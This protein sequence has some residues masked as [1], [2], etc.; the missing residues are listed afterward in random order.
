[1]TNRTTALA[2]EAVAGATRQPEGI[3]VDDVVYSEHRRP[4]IGNEF[5]VCNNQGTCVEVCKAPKNQEE[6]G[7]K[8]NW[9]GA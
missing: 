5:N 4:G 8:E 7:G 3:P 1:V 2:A 9:F 6:L